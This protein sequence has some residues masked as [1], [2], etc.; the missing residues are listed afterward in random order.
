[1]TSELAIREQAL[2]WSMRTGDPAF[3]DWEAF[4]LWL[5]EDPAHARAYDEVCAAVADAADLIG[6]AA[7][8]NDSGGVYAADADDDCVG[9][10][11]TAMDSAALAWRCD[12]RITGADR[13]RRAV[14]A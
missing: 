10:S 11:P 1:M 12:S 3:A 4:T 7:P 5:D 2:D 14:A 9:A 13:C 6:E 8:A